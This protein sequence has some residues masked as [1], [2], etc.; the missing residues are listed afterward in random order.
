MLR[1]AEG[2][3]QMGRRQRNVMIVFFLLLVM[4]VGLMVA[5]DF[6]GPASRASIAPVASEGFKVVLAAMVG[7]LSATLGSK[8]EN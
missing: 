3:R 4:C 6:L 7:A 2:T 1:R 5:A 8:D